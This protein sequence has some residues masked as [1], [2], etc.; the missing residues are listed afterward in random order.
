MGRITVG[1]AAL[2]VLLAGPAVRGKPDDA[3]DAAIRQK[4]KTLIKPDWRSTP[5][6]LD[7]I[8]NLLAKYHGVEVE[9]DKGAFD[10]AGVKDVGSRRVEFPNLHSVRLETLLELTIRPVNGTLQIDKGRL[11]IIPGKP[12][13]ITSVAPPAGEA[14]RVKMLKKVTLERPICNAPLRDILEF[15][16]DKYELN[17]FL[18]TSAFAKAGRR[19]VLDAPCSSPEANSKLIECLNY[20]AVQVEGKVLA[21]DEIILILPQTKP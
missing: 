4:L 21:R 12:R 9:I 8:L 15:L 17:V 19:A 2:V 6:T 13:E 1:C 20:F 10:K 11:R 3:A 16:S 5:A 14:M 18:D 7:E